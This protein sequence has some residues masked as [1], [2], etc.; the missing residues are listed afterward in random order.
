M[1]TIHLNRRL[2]SVGYQVGKV[3]AYGLP[4]GL[5]AVGVL[6]LSNVYGAYSDVPVSSV[7]SYTGCPLN[8]YNSDDLY[9]VD[10]CRQVLAGYDLRGFHLPPSP[11]IFPDMVLLLPCMAIS[12]D[13]GIIFLAYSLLYY[14][15]TAIVLAWIGRCCGFSK[16]EA[17]LYGCSAVTSLLATHLSAPYHPRALLLAHPGNH[18]GIILVG[19]LLTALTFHL[20][21]WGPRVLSS[22]TFLLAGALG[23]FSDRLL[24]VQFLVPLS[25]A[26]LV[27]T[28]FRLLSVRRLVAGAVW[29]GGSVLVG[30]GLRRLSAWLGLIL[31]PSTPNIGLATRHRILR[32]LMDEFPN[33]MRGQYTAMTVLVVGLLIAAVIV[34][35][36]VWERRPQTMLIGLLWVFACSS[37]LI[38]AL[39][40]GLGPL[41]PGFGRY[42]LVLVVLPFLLLTFL[43]RLLP[44]RARLAGP[45]F[46]V[47]SIAASL[48]Q[49]GLSIPTFSWEHLR[50]PYP[51]FVRAVDDL[52][53]QWGCYYGLADFWNARS[54]SMLS[55]K[56]IIAKPLSSAAVPWLHSDNPNAWLQ[57]D[58]AD[59]S[60]PSYQFI[61]VSRKALADTDVAIATAFDKYSVPAERCTIGPEWEIW[62]YDDM[63]C[64]RFSGFLAGVLAQ[65]YRRTRHFEAPLS[66]KELAQPKANL[67][68]WDDQSNFQMTPGKDLE[69]LFDHPV[70]AGAIDL[71]ADC[72]SAYQVTLYCGEQRLGDVLAPSSWT[73][74]TFDYDRKVFH[75]IFSRLLPLSADMRGRPCDRAIVRCLS[76]GAHARLGHFLIF[77]DVPVLPHRALVSQPRRFEAEDL[78]PLPRSRIPEP[79][80]SAG[81]IRQA[82]K[83]HVSWVVCGPYMPLYPGHYRV[84]FAIRCD[85]PVGSE[86][87]AKVDAAAFK[88]DRILASRELGAGD[89]IA[90]KGFR[91]FSLVIRTECELDF[92]EFRLFSY[93]RTSLAIDYIDLIPLQP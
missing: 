24:V 70:A 12:K 30:E 1:G 84:D 25:L 34:V 20:V 27:L 64:P 81:Q 47:A 73:G 10:V 69:V 62:R 6:F 92:V 53:S 88:G 76:E 66:P 90:D 55:R 8:T 39:L 14:G 26:L 15:L 80:A 91:I 43:L 42:T 87:V 36:A 52:A 4:A 16:R 28:C 18:A 74:V 45:V 3:F 65:K 46:A 83:G 2:S 32:F 72:A 48:V 93:G 5:V 38:I 61:I 89:F 57:T 11:Y 19:L 68:R 22:V 82:E 79:S 85:G 23:A 63:N 75:T 29:I 60:V 21:Q 71:A 67:S 35:I 17:W 7:R 31:L 78:D 49:M 86:Q 37:T 33:C 41:A 58:D 77:T 40:V 44:S 59:P 9:A 54:V 50:Q 13:L 56:G 51:P